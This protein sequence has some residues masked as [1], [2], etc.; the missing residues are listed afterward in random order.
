VGDEDYVDDVE[1]YDLPILQDT[2]AADVFGTYE[3][4]SY[5]AYLIDR[6]GYV[7]WAND[8]FFPLDDSPALLEV[9]A[10]FE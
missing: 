5:A 10:D 6:E 1:D 7:A 2:E 3:A 4:Y 9:L 8:R